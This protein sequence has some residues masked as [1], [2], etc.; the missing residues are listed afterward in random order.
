MCYHVHFVNGCH[1]VNNFNRDM[2]KVDY[3]LNTFNI[4]NED[5]VDLNVSTDIVPQIAGDWHRKKCVRDLVVYLV[6]HDYMF[7]CVCMCGPTQ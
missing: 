1:I 4:T 5:T 3:S 6:N 7:T 2:I